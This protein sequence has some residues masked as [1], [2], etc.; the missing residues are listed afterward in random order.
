MKTS[1]K[2][3][4]IHRF[5]K[6]LNDTK[7][8]I[9]YGSKETEDLIYSIQDDIEFLDEENEESVDTIYNNIIK[10]ESL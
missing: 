7:L 10:L 9:W 6:S 8:D 1:E 5:N 2:L 4:Y 3:K